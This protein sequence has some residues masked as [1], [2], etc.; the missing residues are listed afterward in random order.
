MNNPGLREDKNLV[1]IIAGLN[2]GDKVTEDRD[3]ENRCP[4]TCLPICLPVTEND[5]DSPTVRAATTRTL[6]PCRDGQMPSPVV[7]SHGE[8]P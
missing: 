1:R 2:V 8:D 3:D 7:S 4:A 6:R 5:S